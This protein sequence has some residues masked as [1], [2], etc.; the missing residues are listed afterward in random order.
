MEA[1]AVSL[2]V[3]SCFR[4]LPLGWLRWSSYWLQGEHSSWLCRLPVRLTFPRF[5]IQRN[6]VFAADGLV[7]TG[8]AQEGCDLLTQLR[9]MPFCPSAL[10]S[11]LEPADSSSVS[12]LT[13]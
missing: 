2:L 3:I 4:A 11:A 12:R 13:S 10:S 1:M 8:L 7:M 6:T 5:A 9:A